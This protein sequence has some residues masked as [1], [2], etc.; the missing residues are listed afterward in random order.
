MFSAL[1]A[2]TNNF[3]ITVGLS[4]GDDPDQALADALFAQAGTDDKNSISAT[5]FRDGRLPILNARGLSMVMGISRLL[6]L[7]QYAAGMPLVILAVIPLSKYNVSF[8]SRKRATPSIGHG[9]HGTAFALIT[10]LLYCICL[11]G[12]N[13]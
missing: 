5:H 12:C 6:L 10:L 4:A 7:V 3:D 2:F 1:A 11:I 9:A 8:L 13:G